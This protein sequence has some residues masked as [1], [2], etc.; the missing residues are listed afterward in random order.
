MAHSFA[1][2]T[3]VSLSPKLFL[4]DFTFHKTDNVKVTFHSLFTLLS[5]VFECQ[6]IRSL[7]W[8]LKYAKGNIPI[9]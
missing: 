7:N 1:V 4:R 9:S 2:L 3:M 8:E 5:K 6:L